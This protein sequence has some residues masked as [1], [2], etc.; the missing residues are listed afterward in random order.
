MLSI[1]QMLRYLT[2]TFYRFKVTQKK[3]VPDYRHFKTTNKLSTI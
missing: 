2:L 3:K 1:I